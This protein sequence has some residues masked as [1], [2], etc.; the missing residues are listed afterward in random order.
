[1]HI[2]QSPED[3]VVEELTDAAPGTAGVYGLYR[4]E[5]KG[6]TTPDALRVI[7]QRWRLQ[8]N[9]VSFGG[10]K[11]RHAHTVQYLTIV[12]G[13][14]RRMQQQ[15]IAVSYL[16]QVEEPY[17]S[18]HIRANRFAVTIRDLTQA[19]ARAAEEA[20]PEVRAGGVPNYFDDQRFGSVADGGPFLARH[21]I[22]GQY[23]EALRL[24]LTAPYRYDRSEQKKEKA[25]LR[26]GWGD[27]A[28]CLGRLPRSPA[29]G[30]VEHLARHP[31]DFL[32]AFARL[33]PDLRGLYLSAYQSHLWNRMLAHWLRDRL[34]ADRLLMIPLRQGDVPMPR[35]LTDAERRDLEGLALPLPS[36]RAGLDGDDPRT[37]VL[38]RVLDEE[39][40]QPE[41]FRLKGPRE[42]YFARG[43]R[44]A[45]C[46]PENLQAE[47]AAD[48][49]HRGRLKLTLRFDLPRGSYATLIVK[50]ITR[51]PEAPE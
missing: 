13:P 19:E 23:E 44:A 17:T 8:P 18:Q 15:G 39:Q 28:R 32:G 20:L 26:A 34:P 41:Q 33:R 22:L 27:W 5:K 29:R 37:A 4:L 30:P 47:A 43:E 40:L 21:V 7:Q 50:R 42:L 35:T 11:D 16:G 10:L 14:Q 36:A 2:K 45:L 38:R 9:R 1:M 12:R 46:L 25:I 24:A 3:F 51:L 6:W 31:D 48:E 49:Q